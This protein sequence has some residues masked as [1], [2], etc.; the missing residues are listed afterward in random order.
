MA[1][2]RAA[3]RMSTKA[4]TV[5]AIAPLALQVI[6]NAAGPWK[7]PHPS[8]NDASVADPVQVV[9]VVYCFCIMTLSSHETLQEAHPVLNRPHIHTYI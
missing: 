1:T 7:L 3:P 2:A 9:L 8:G 6:I 4:C 5:T